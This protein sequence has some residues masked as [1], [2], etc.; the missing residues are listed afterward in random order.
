MTRLADHGGDARFRLAI[1]GHGRWPSTYYVPG[2][3]RLSDV[4]IVAVCGRDGERASAF[5]AAHGIPR[6]YDSIERMLA[7]ENLDG[8]IIAT[9]PSDHEAAVRAVSESRTPVLCEK[10]LALDGEGARRIRDLLA[11]RPALTGFTLRWHPLFRELHDAIREGTVGTVK[12]VRIR[13]LQSSAATPARGWNWHFDAADEPLG[14]VSDLG[15]HAIDL[16]R[17]MLGEVTQVEA[18][19][20]TTITERA[21]DTGVLRPVTN[22]DDADLHLT[23]ESGSTAAL[24]ISRVSPDVGVPGSIT[25]EVLGARGWIRADS[26]EEDVVVGT[27]SGT[28]RRPVPVT[29]FADG[30]DAQL[31]DFVSV[32]RGDH[33][34][35]LPSIDDGYRAQLVMDAVAQALRTGAAV[36]LR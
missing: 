24:T 29:S 34:E 22:H 8:V 7:A 19:S 21:G 10:P 15:P 23:A 3:Q 18:R 31:S 33:R 16:V 11:D 28:H 4:E 2:A 25:V 5:A 12:H 20:R 36:A 13:Y 14:V 30:A 6:S 26:N 35:A 9:P 17:W 32:S 1:I 27:A